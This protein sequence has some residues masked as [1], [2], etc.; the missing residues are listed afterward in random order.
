MQTFDRK[1]VRQMEDEMVAVLNKY[2]FEN[3][4]F[5]GAGAR[6]EPAECTFK[7]RGTV[8]GVE[9]VQTR[10]QTDLERYAALDGIADITKRGPK[11]EEL[12]EYHTR[13][14]KYPYIYKTVRGAR[15]K[16]TPDQAKR[17]FG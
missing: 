14:P 2:G 5:A 4:T 17:M 10:K 6:Y 15:Y 13:K 1:T 11:G 16:C 9:G 8:T 3:V 12:I 7:I